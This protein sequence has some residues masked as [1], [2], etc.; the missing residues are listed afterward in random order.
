MTASTEKYKLPD[1]ER[2]QIIGLLAIWTPYPESMYE[3]MSDSELKA[4]FE[5]AMNG[6]LA[7]E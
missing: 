5:R 3:A 4:E 6:S 7:W 2:D 1:H